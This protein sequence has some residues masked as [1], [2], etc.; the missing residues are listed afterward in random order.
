MG[1]YARRPPADTA[2][3]GGGGGDD[4][5]DVAV[6]CDDATGAD[7]PVI[8]GDGVISTHRWTTTSS[9]SAA[10]AAS[11]ASSSA[12]LVELLAMARSADGAAREYA[13]GSL[14]SLLAEDGG[15]AALDALGAATG[16]HVLYAAATDALPQVRVEAVGA[17]RCV[18]VYVM[19]V[20]VMVM[21][22]MMTLLMHND[23][24]IDDDVMSDSDAMFDS[25]VTID[26]QCLD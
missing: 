8:D 21:V 24:T 26:T 2:A 9:S 20:M 14:A 23:V 16:L 17:L 15:C 5:S 10:A 6:D 18:H 1:R 25:D 22:M 3:G 13:C 12:V 19:M 4:A 7:A 11:S